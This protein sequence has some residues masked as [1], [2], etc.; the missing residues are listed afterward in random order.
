MER[1]TIK[2]TAD[3]R[4]GLEELLER[5]HFS[6]VKAQRAR[7]LLLADSDLTDTEI[8]EELECGRN[9]AWRIRKRAVLE[10]IPAALE[11]KKQV[12]PSRKPVLDGRGEAHLIRLACS[13]PPEGRARWTL[14]LLADQLVELEVVE[15]VSVTTVHR[16]LKKTASSLGK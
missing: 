15:T 14:T 8:A 3:E 2:L 4:A 7:I 12:A 10:G 1:Y 9:T 5:R 13:E 16:R 11:R 6:K